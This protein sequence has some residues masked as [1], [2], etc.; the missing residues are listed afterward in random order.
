MQC[1]RTLGTNMKKPILLTTVLLFS[2]NA[3]AQTKRPFMQFTSYPTVTLCEFARSP[4]L[5]DGKV[6]RVVG[7][8]YISADNTLVLRSDEIVK[9]KCEGRDSMAT[10]WARRSP[11][12]TTLVDA[13]IKKLTLHTPEHKR[14]SVEVE[15][16]GKVVDGD[17]NHTSC[18]GPRFWIEATS[19]KQLS[20][21]MPLF[22][23]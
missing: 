16:I 12:V 7:L 4:D 8:A 14:T 21:A 22:L 13:F 23:E 2:L 19:I 3:F 1:L 5:Y 17:K 15:T 11:G 10:L 18:F 9:G 6:V 20:P